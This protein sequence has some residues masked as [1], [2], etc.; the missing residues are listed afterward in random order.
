MISLFLILVSNSTPSNTTRRAHKTIAPARPQT[1]QKTPAHQ[2]NAVPRS[3]GGK[4]YY[5]KPPRRRSKRHKIVAP[6]LRAPRPIKRG[7]GALHEIRHYQKGV[8]H[9]IPKKPF[10]RLVREVAQEHMVCIDSFFYRQ[11]HPTYWPFFTDQCPANTKSHRSAAR[12]SRRVPHKVIFGRKPPR[13]PRTTSNSDTTGYK[14][15]PN[16]SKQ[17]GL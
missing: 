1:G 12:C 3:T 2:Y 10:E 6:P 14:S 4:T 17:C 9:L 11:T 15:C 7:S 8:D 16:A 13:A 5:P